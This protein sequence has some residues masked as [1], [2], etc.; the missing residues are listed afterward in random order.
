MNLREDIQRKIDLKTKPLGALGQLETIAHQICCVQKT[1]APELKHPHLV[2]FAADHGLAEEGISAY[3]SEVT[4][5]MVR[6]FLNGGAA[7]NVFCEQHQ[8]ELKIV[9]SGVKSDFEKHEKLL[10]AKAGY[11]TANALYHPAMSEEQLHFCLHNGKNLVE[12]I[13][14]TTCNIIGFG[15]MGIGNTSSASL[16]LA[17][18][19]QMPIVELTGRGTGVNDAQLQ[20]KINTL[21]KV[22]NN[23]Q[24]D[25]TKPLDVLQEV[26]GFEIAQMCGAMLEAYSQGMLLMI[27]GFIATA[28]IVVCKALEPNILEHCIFC[29]SSDEQAHAA[30]LSLLNVTPILQLKLRVGEG[31]GCALAYPILQSAVDFM[32]KMAS[33]EDAKV[34]NK[35]A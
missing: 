14:K 33:F 10:I 11:G 20:S 7:I 28:A 31:T 34:S 21:R 3:P 25:S 35:D 27:D 26:G 8:I 4:Q 5:Q 17:S 32:N 1:T 23:R 12:N 9:D 18:L 6:N 19:L 22:L 15:E 13:A 16:I 30:I 24:V 29:H 2:V